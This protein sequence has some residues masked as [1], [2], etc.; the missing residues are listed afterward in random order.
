LK[1]MIFR[2]LFFSVPVFLKITGWTHLKS[3]QRKNVVLGENLKKL[4]DMLYT[5]YTIT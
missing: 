4:H 5:S 1:V 2:G 3:Y